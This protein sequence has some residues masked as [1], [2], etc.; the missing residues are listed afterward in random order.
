MY[1]V[2]KSGISTPCSSKQRSMAL[3]L[4]LYAWAICFPSVLDAQERAPNFSVTIEL[5]KNLDNAEPAFRLSIK[6]ESADTTSIAIPLSIDFKK[7]KIR[8]IGNIIL[9]IQEVKNG[10]Y[11]PFAPSADIDPVFQ[12]QEI[13]TLAGKQSFVDTIYIDRRIFAKN[14][15]IHTGQSGK[16]RVR[17]F[18]NPDMWNRSEKIKSEWL[19]FDIKLSK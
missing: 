3:L 10:E 11:V 7:E 2:E 9:E 13:H 4:F 19:A 14:A 6:N 17:V 16:Y 18:F 12:P 1:S 5:I 8:A 15:S